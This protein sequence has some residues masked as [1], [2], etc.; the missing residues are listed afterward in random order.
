M[1]E[2][3]VPEGRGGECCSDEHDQ[4]CREGGLG[5][6][7]P[8]PGG[9][10]IDRRDQ[11]E[12]PDV[13]PGEY[14]PGLREAIREARR[15]VLHHSA[16]SSLTLRYPKRNTAAMRTMRSTPYAAAAPKSNARSSERIAMEMGRV[17]CV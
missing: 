14:P 12:P 4:R 11:A 17:R 2:V 5:A 13:D 15:A 3:R 9:D 7:A 6:I 8:G 16:G 10:Q 1:R